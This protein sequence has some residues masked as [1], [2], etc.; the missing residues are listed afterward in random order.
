MSTPLLIEMT[1]KG[2]SELTLN[3][4]KLLSLAVKLLAALCS[5]AD[6]PPPASDEKCWAIMVQTDIMRAFNNMV[7]N[8]G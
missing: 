6:T 5:H 4:I 8:V 3:E 2:P 1:P 7:L